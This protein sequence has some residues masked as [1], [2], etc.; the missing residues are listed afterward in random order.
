MPGGEQFVRVGYA[1]DGEA[2]PDAFCDAV[3]VWGQLAGWGEDQLGVDELFG[4]LF[5]GGAPRPKDPVNAIW[6]S[7]APN[8]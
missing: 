5:S 6:S 3:G 1:H 7:T 2:A 8:S 4:K